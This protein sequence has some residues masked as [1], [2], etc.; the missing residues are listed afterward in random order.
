MNLCIRRAQMVRGALCCIQCRQDA[1]H[2]F[3]FKFSHTQPTPS[4]KRTLL[5][6]PNYKEDFDFDLATLRH[7]KSPLA[8]IG[9]LEK[10]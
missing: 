4:P 1:I 10:C 5:I 7:K 6:V 2:N 8:C 9:I 3:A